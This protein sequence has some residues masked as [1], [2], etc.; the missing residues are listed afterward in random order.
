MSLSTSGPGAAASSEGHRA[1]HRND[2][3]PR[4]D[5]YQIA[6]ESL[7]Y[8]IYDWDV[9]AGTIYVSPELAITL[10]RPP[11]QLANP[12]RWMEFIHPDDF[13]VYRRTLVAYLKGET[14]RFE[15]EYRVRMAD[16]AWGWVRQHGVA[17]RRADGR[18]TRLTGAARDITEIKQR[19]RQFATAKAEVAAHR[20]GGPVRE[21]AE[22]FEER[23]ALAMESLSFGVYDWNIE[24]DELYCS[25][26]LRIM[27]GLSAAELAR[28]Q[29]WFSRIHPDDQ[30]IMRRALIEHFKGE[31]PK[32]ECETRYRAHDGTWRWARQH[33][34]AL[35]RPDGRAYRMIGA[36][37]DT[38]EIK[39]RER[40]LHAAKLAAAHQHESYEI[41]DQ[42]EERYAL[43][44]E[45]INEN[46]YDWN[47]ETGELYFSPRLRVMLG[48]GPDEPPTLKNWAARIHPE[49]RPLHQRTLV[50]HFK[51]ETARFECEFRYSTLDDNWRW[52]RQ[53]G[54]AL[55]HR[56]GRAYRMVGATGDIT[57]SKQRERE[58]R[59]A[60]AEAEAAHRDVEQTRE[61]MQVILDNMQ[62]GV[63][64]YDKNFNWVFS[65]RKT[66]DLMRWPPDLL[67]PGMPMRDILRFQASRGEF[68]PTDD[69]DARVEEAVA[70]MT[71]PEG[72]RY[73]RRTL[74]GRHVEFNFRRLDDGSILGLYRDITALKEREQVITSAK[75]AAEQS[76]RDVERTR[77]LMQLVLDNMSGGVMLFDKDQRLQFVNPQLIEFQKYPPGFIQPGVTTS[78]DVLRFQI[79][80]GDFGKVDDIEAKIKER[81]AIIYKPGGNRFVRRTASGRYIEFTTQPLDEGGVLAIGRDI[82]E[83]QERQAALAAAKDV[84][85]K[86]RD[87]AERERSEAEAANQAKSTF[88][89]TMSHEIRTPMNGVL[90]MIDVLE[91][92]GLSGVQQ[93]TVATIRDSAQSLMRIIDDVLDFSKIEAGRL[94]LEETSFSLSGL[95]EGVV[96][97]FR[98]Q[99]MSKGLDLEV[100]IDPGSDDALVGDPTRVRQIMFNLLGNALKFTE[101]G[102]VRV[103]A[104]TAPLG[105]GMTRVTLA[106]SDTG[107]GLDSEQQARLFRPFA[108][109]D[110]STTRR[111]GGTG[112]GLSI[113]RRL[114]QLMHGDVTVESLSRVGSTFTVT[115]QLHAAP[116]DSPLNTTLRSSLRTS[117]RPG[118]ARPRIR[119]RVL[120][121]DDHPVNRE[122]LVRQLELLGIAAD[123]VN[124]GVDALA[125][126]DSGSYAAVLAD[127]H[128]PRMDG[129]EFTREV[130]NAEIKR[131]SAR[132]PIV[133]VTAN[134]MKGEDERCIAAGMDAYLAKPVNIEQLR[135]TLERWMPVHEEGGAP[136]ET[137]SSADTVAAFDRDVLAAWLGN[138]RNAINSLLAKFRDTAI[139]AERV[140]NS[141]SRAGDLAELAAAAHKLKGAALTVGATGISRAAAVLEQ[142]GKAGDR[143][144]C[145]E[146]LG[147]LAVELRR[148]IAE[149][150]RSNS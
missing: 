93:R 138:D 51:G 42:D 115:L 55:R 127:I 101:R 95:I 3:K 12:E 4:D 61:V 116:A 19:E 63:T 124:D 41:F 26:S 78:D 57:E 22:H 82:T 25:P 111:F 62:D 102:H 64:L 8:G 104:G 65:N 50:A 85:E 91:R 129:H 35:K 83:V 28:A 145:R 7:G 67:T 30:P 76:R 114:A 107:I 96:G 29:S 68:G 128:M 108:Q 72:N 150:E 40:E 23:Y 13:P 2:Q 112:L 5:R 54:I 59:S 11:E 122:V 70:R 36:T 135:L 84:A 73:E 142:A 43:A 38:T 100:E 97:T 31:T 33:G 34:I 24:T 113:V 98:R 94:E 132:T 117:K 126:W 44:L 48:M 81:S 18:V 134:A 109:A 17:Q 21:E 147:P 106:V 1:P 60:R 32:Y 144:R 6:I 14:P 9:E 10:G 146:G 39:H 87:A 105:G 123:T 71:K 130:R 88:L 133:A 69:L 47:I 77:K 37:G 90:G 46:V 140:I 58:L 74:S 52:A 53:H 75:E 99:A 89:A 49:D 15:C 119:P 120:V 110:S 131:G 125:A 56:D 143:S 66:Y 45:S 16:G 121:A 79:E 136:G 27:L 137:K 141:S 139:E 20:R 148:A 86:A 80:R 92:Q 103:H 149:I 118:D